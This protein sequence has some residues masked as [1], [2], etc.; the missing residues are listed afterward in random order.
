M[1]RAAAVC[2]LAFALAGGAWAAPP[3]A[4]PDT[5]RV[6]PHGARYHAA[7]C[8]SIRGASEVVR[9]AVADSVGYLPCRRCLAA[10]A[11]PARKATRFERA[12]GRA[13]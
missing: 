1:K 8:A 10:P 11:R 7:G 6:T 4:L 2:A 12:T 9:R 5:V 13:K 3:R